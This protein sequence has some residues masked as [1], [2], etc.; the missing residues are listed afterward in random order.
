MN[1]R[2]L[3]LVVL[4][5]VLVWACG[6]G[7]SSGTDA[8][9]TGADAGGGVDPL[10]GSWFLQVTTGPESQTVTMT[11][12]AGG[13]LTL[14]HTQ[15]NAATASDHASCLEVVT[16]TGTFAESGGQTMLTLTPGAAG[17]STRTYSGCASAADDGTA[18]YT[19]TPFLTMLTSAYTIAA[20]TLT[21]SFGG[22]TTVFVRR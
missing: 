14:V 7:G 13:A 3:L 5:V 2:T 4:P 9:S 22:M 1:V 19:G 16:E 21:I 6:G 15:Q 17:T 18:A 12:V 11:F 8:S 20:D 10:L